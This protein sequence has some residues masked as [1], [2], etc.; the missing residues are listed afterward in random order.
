MLFSLNLLCWELLVGGQ[1]NSS[2]FYGFWGKLIKRVLKSEKISKLNFL[3]IFFNFLFSKMLTSSSSIQWPP[4][5]GWLFC[6]FLGVC[7][8]MSYFKL[9]TIFNFHLIKM[10]WSSLIYCDKDFMWYSRWFAL[11]FFIFSK[12]WRYQRCN[13]KP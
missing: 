10:Y 3:P 5:T 9:C 13:Q 1:G 8:F 2:I 7:I 11:W 6:H 4:S 12:V